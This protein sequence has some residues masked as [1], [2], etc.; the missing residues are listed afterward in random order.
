MGP[1]LAIDESLSVAYNISIRYIGG[2]Y[3]IPDIGAI[4]PLS[5]DWL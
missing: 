1:A 2:C 3:G 4:D 5:Y